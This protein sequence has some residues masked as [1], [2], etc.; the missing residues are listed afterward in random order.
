[1]STIVEECEPVTEASAK[2]TL[3]HVCGHR[4]LQPKYGVSLR[5]PAVNG[6]QQRERTSQSIQ[7][8]QILYKS[9]MIMGTSY[10]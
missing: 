3:Q 9:P 5:S 1:M 4:S 10:V 7:R 2:W 6:K 8:V